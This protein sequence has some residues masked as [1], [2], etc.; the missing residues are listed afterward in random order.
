[1]T[2]K[3]VLSIILIAATLSTLPV[4]AD[5]DDVMFN[6]R[7]GY[8]NFKDRVDDTKD[9]VGDF[10]EDVGDAKNDITDTIK[11]KI[12]GWFEPDMRKKDAN[13]RRNVEKQDA[14]DEYKKKRQEINPSGFMTLEEYERR[15]LYQDHSQD[16]IELPKPEKESD[17]KYVP[18]F[19]YKIVRYNNPPGS[20]ELSIKKKFYTMKHMNLQGIAD[21][22]FSKLVYP[23]VYYYAN[24]ASVACELFVI[25]LEQNETN[26]NK[27][28]KA[29]VKKRLPDA[30]LSTDRTI[31]NAL[32]FR[33]LTPI[34]FSSDG[35]LLLVKEKVGNSADGIWKTNAIVY[36]FDTKMSYDLVEVRDAISYFWK[37]NKNLNLEDKRWD[38]YPVG[39]DINNPDRIIVQAYGFTGEKPVFLGTWSVDSKGEQSRLETFVNADSH[40]SMN[41]FKLVQD[42]VIN[43]SVTAAEEKQIQR[44]EKYQ[45]RAKRDEEKAKRDALKEEYKAKINAIDA[46]YDEEQHNFNLQQKVKGTTSGNDAVEMYEQLKAEEIRKFIEKQEKLN[47]KERKLIEKLRVEAQKYQDAANAIEVPTPQLSE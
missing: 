18:Q 45:E 7:D 19:T 26:L 9:V 37:E 41:G 38:I 15:S 33:T 34:D 40:V 30:I 10:K 31:D 1:M 35:N 4:L 5:Y 16:E 20:P 42:G 24:G 12:K 44:Y 17:M 13:Y 46:K 28:L 22:N 14:R 32:T 23:V 8:E 21:P 27:L 47:E 43:P 36:H 25:P 39:F 11:S 6:I 2:N 29:N 3:K